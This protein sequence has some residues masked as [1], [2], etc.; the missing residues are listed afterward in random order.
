MATDVGSFR[1]PKTRYTSPD[2]AALELERMWPRV[3]QIACTIDHVSEPGD[4]FEYRAGPLSVLVVRGD[5]GE[6]RAFQNACRHRGNAICTGAAQGLTELRCPFHRW[7]YDLDGRLREVPNRKAFGPLD[8]DQLSLVEA[9]VGTWGPLV[10]VNLDRDCMPLADYLAPVPDDIAWAGIDDF[11]CLATVTTPV[12]ANWKVVTDGFSETYHVPGLHPELNVSMDDGLPQRVWEHTGCSQ[13]DYGVPN[14]RVPGLGDEDVWASF[15]ATQGVRAGYDEKAPMPDLGGRSVAE[16][17][18]EGIVATQAAAGVDLSGF[19]TEQ[20]LRLHQY[21][22]FPNATVLVFV[23]LLT[24]L[25]GRPSSQPNST[26]DDGELVFYYFQRVPPG[27]PRVRPADV[28]SPEG[29]ADLG[30]VFN[31][32]IGILESMQR[33]LRQP[34]LRHLTVSAFECRLLNTHRNLERYLGIGPDD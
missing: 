5:D 15:V 8:D 11:R 33:G 22:V 31:Q 16:V 2:F 10:F 3:W 26:V 29:Q 23:D 27:A 12:R 28:V 24:V 21:N 7:S 6:L 18:A 17:L 19:T 34:G 1:I 4:V 20:L 25:L 32:D 30:L 13:Q 9:R 14:P